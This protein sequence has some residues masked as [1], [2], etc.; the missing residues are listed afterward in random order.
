MSSI[1]FF[2]NSSA[3]PPTPS[4]VTEKPAEQSLESKPPLEVM[5]TFGLHYLMEEDQLELIDP[6]NAL[7]RVT[8]GSRLP[9]MLSRFVARDLAEAHF[10][11][12]AVPKVAR[13]P[14]ELRRKLA[15]REN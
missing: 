12:R 10:A 4:A 11:T 7:P 9:P 2:S 1:A 3:P 5:Q 14:E 13:T 8:H 15:E 6:Q